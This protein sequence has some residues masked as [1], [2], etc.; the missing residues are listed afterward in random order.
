M[1]SY[2]IDTEIEVYNVNTGFH[3]A[4]AYVKVTDVALRYVKTKDNINEII[5]CPRHIY[6]PRCDK[7]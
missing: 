6:S 4:H 5:K 2:L 7:L 1:K 3:E